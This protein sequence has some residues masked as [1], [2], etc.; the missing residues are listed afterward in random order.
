M[1][2][3]TRLKTAREDA[4]LSQEALGKAVGIGRA[5]ISKIEAGGTKKTSHIV[6]LAEV[7]CVSPLWLEFGEGDMAP[8]NLELSGQE[9]E[10]LVL[11]RSLN[12]A[13]RNVVRRITK[14]LSKST[15]E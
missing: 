5:A 8:S 14:G 13:D 4:N 1:T 2:L 12:R 3:A 11:Y 15:Y 10:L 9:K 7:L 6:K